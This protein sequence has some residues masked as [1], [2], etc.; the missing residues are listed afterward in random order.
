MKGT[1]FTTLGEMIEHEFGLEV[2]QMILDACPISNG[3][4]YSSGGMYPDEELFCLV[5][6]LQK[7]LDIPLDILLRHFGTFLFQELISSHK[8]M[9]QKHKTPKSFLMA[10]DKEIHQEIEKI[11]PKASFP[12]LNYI[13]ES[14]DELSI[15]YKSPRKLCFLAEGIIQGVCEAYNT[16][17]A[18]I[19]STCMHRGD[20]QCRLDISF[21]N[22]CDIH[23]DE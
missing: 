18:L 10:V 20:D 23:H 19:H 9:L 7:H 11:Y 21:Y 14:E 4:G 3:G 13:D 8:Y 6:K 16:E 17:I 5:G 15:I 22:K 1:I 2:W 12:F